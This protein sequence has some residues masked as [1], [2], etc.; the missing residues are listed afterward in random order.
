MNLSATGTRY[1]RLKLGSRIRWT[2]CRKVRVESATADLLLSYG[3]QSG[4]TLWQPVVLFVANP[5]TRFDFLFPP[6][7]LICR[8]FSTVSA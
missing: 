8:L 4:T 7:Y 5:R 2:A 3:S 6:P 1:A